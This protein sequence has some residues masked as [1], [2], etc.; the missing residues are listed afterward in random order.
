MIFK[1]KKTNKTYTELS[2]H[3]VF[4]EHQARISS[5]FLIQK[6][7]LRKIEGDIVTIGITTMNNKHS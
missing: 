4:L 2:S 3:Q 6:S 1:E 5:F 7:F